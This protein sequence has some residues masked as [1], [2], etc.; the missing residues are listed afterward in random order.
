MGRKIQIVMLAIVVIVAIGAATVLPSLADESSS[1][2]HFT[3]GNS[4]PTSLT[5]T[6]YE[7]NE[8]TEATSM[9]PQTEYAL[10]ITVTDWN[11]LN[12]IS[13]IEVIIK[14]NSTN[15]DADDSPTDKA[16]YKWTSGGWS[17][18]GPS[19]STWN[20]TDDSRAPSNLNDTTGTWWLHFIPGKV[21]RE[22][23]SGGWDIYVNVTDKGGLSTNNI[24]GYDMNWYGEI[25]ASD[26]SYSFGEINLGTT[27]QGITSP[28]DGYI[29]VKTISNG[30]Y[31][32]QSK[33]DNWQDG[34]GNT[35]VLD[36]D[37]NLSSGEFA[38]KVSYQNNVNN[39]NFVET[40]YTVITGY[41]S[42]SGPTAEAG[43][44][45]KIYQWISVADSGL[46]PGTYS[47]TFYVQINNND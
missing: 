10:K 38:L 4:A 40:D 34:N 6:L 7:S 36:W 13:E 9:T 14:T 8:S 12:D 2:G 30:N 33:S 46:L 28:N 32:I 22:S 47:G 1:T 29:D 26:T 39:S 27:D 44:T 5:F 45:K 16:T 31:K 18:V 24:A 21:A 42:E 19:D 20:I 37:G 43:E 25:S 35:A 15:I 11:T 23:T 41:E 17:L 3:L